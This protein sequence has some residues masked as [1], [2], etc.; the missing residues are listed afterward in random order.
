[1]RIIKGSNII[2][3]SE[4]AFRVV[5]QSMGYSKYVPKPRKKKEEGE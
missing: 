2:E 3:V 4:K 1:M 5:Y